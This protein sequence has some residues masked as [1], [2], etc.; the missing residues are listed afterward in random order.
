MTILTC[1][2]LLESIRVL[3]QIEPLNFLVGRLVVVGTEISCGSSP[4]PAQ[5]GNR[6]IFGFC[7][8]CSRT[9]RGKYISKV[10]PLVF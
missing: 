4:N 5:L 10:W 2:G 6:V 3:F 1:S 7:T 9:T 8:I